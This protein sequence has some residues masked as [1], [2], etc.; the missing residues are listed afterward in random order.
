AFTRSGD[1]LG[2][3]SRE[4]LLPGLDR[5]ADDAELY[6]VPQD[7][8]HGPRSRD[9]LGTAGRDCSHSTIP[10]LRRQLVLYRPMA[11]PEWRHLHGMSAAGCS[12]SHLTVNGLSLTTPAISRAFSVGCHSAG[13]HSSVGTAGVCPSVFCS[14]VSP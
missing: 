13:A 9:A 5:Y 3:R 6:A 1:G 8:D 14:S 7:V 4:C 10:R 12:T 2:H 11:F